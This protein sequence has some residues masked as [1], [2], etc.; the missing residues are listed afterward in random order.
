MLRRAVVIL[1]AGVLSG[2]PVA[3]GAQ[4]APGIGAFAQGLPYRV[5]DQ[6][7]LFRQSDMGQAIFAQLRQAE[8]RLEA[9]NQQIFDQLTAEERALTEQRA[10][11]TPEEFRALADA[12]DARVETIRAERAARAQTLVDVR[13][14]EAQRFF[15]AA[16]PVLVDL[17]A[18]EGIV[19]LFRP[20][21][22]VLG[23]D[24]IDVTD[25][26][27]ERMNA[28]TAAQGQAPTVPGTEAPAP[29]SPA[30]ESPTPEPTRQP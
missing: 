18:S 12:F 27:I 20:E 28:A 25:L 5:L 22:I 8:Q 11:M 17:M 24:A 14:A 15:D 2:A 7:R 6:D 23:I 13:E 16:L 30:P 4:T 3:V 10:S 1:V 26:A 9:E 29:E 21:N 19:A